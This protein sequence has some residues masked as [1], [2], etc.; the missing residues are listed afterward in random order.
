MTDEVQISI[1]DNLPMD[2]AYFETHDLDWFLFDENGH[3]AIFPTRG[4]GF[5][6]NIVRKNYNKV[7]L[8]VDDIMAL[9]VISGVKFLPNSLK[10]LN[11]AYKRRFFDPMLSISGKGLYQ[12]KVGPER[13]LQSGYSLISVP[14]SPIHIDDLSKVIQKDIYIPRINEKLFLSS[15]FLSPSDLNNITVFD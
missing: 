11:E 3:V 14:E 10:F 12:Y 15:N 8:Y 5:I 6:P 1:R 4:D 2:D 13:R 9:D 7:E